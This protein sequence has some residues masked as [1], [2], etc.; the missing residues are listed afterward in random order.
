[1]V[2]TRFRGPSHRCLPCRSP[3]LAAFCQVIALGKLFLAD[4]AA[5]QGS[6]V[7]VS[8][9]SEVLAGHAD[10]GSLPPLQLALVDEIP[11]LHGAVF[12]T[13]VLLPLGGLAQLFCGIHCLQ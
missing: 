7:L 1:M 6:A 5:E 13:P 9:V 11:V 4:V 2:S 8:P 12:S 3:E 10:A